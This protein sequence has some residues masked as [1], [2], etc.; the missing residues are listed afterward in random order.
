MTRYL[1]NTNIISAVTHISP[2]PAIISWLTAR[3]DTELFIS[4]LTIAEIRKGIDALPQGRKRAA[5]DDWFNGSEGP[6][7]LFAGRILAFDVIAALHWAKLMVE[8][9]A[10]G[11]PRS[12]LDMIIAATALAHDCVIVTVNS[13]DFDLLDYLNPMDDDGLSRKWPL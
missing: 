13:R 6:L 1:L 5:L 3:K 8:G 7:A 2:N 12:A 9:K 4:A 11:R 10:A